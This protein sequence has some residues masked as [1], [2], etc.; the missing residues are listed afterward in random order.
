MVYSMF[1]ACIKL[2]VMQS[3][4]LWVLV[5]IKKPAS[6]I[7]ASRFRNVALHALITR[8]PL[9][10]LMMGCPRY[11]KEQDSSM[12]NLRLKTNNK[13]KFCCCFGRVAEK[14][15]KNRVEQS[16]NRSPM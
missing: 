11:V 10:F 16:M 14:Y 3:A 6:H 8:W 15:A 7:N 5:L 9:C 12:K 13:S 1:N 4:G 2:T